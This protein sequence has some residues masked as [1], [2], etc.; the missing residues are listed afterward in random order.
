MDTLN[1]QISDFRL[2]FNNNKK[3][4]SAKHSITACL[5]DKK[6]LRTRT[7]PT[8]DIECKYRV[9]SMQTREEKKKKLEY[10]KKYLDKLRVEGR[11]S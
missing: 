3:I 8:I 9:V 10:N 7:D 11:G 2:V 6:E 5:S 1:H 4:S